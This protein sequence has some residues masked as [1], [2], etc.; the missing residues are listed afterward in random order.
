MKDPADDIFAEFERRIERAWRQIVGP[1]GSP[2]FC[3]PVIE[4]PADVYETEENV[5]VVV[6]M[7]GINEQEVEIAMEG[8]SLTVRGEREDRQGHLGRLYSQME[9]CCGPFERTLSL[10]ALVDADQA[11]ASYN[12]GFLEIILPKVKRQVS[13]QVRIT[14]R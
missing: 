2:R 5:V 9:I 12:D 14:V 4:P 13:R 7:A 1:P 11:M 6:E 3:P 8:N 10:P